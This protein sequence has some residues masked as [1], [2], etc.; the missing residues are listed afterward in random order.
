MG[1]RDRPPP[2]EDERERAITRLKARIADRRSLDRLTKGA[3]AAERA[4]AGLG[5]SDDEEFGLRSARTASTGG[6]KSRRRT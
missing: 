1:D 3:Q 4:S 5:T 6:S 2:I